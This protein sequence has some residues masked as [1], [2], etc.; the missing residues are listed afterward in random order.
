MLRALFRFL[1][2]N[3]WGNKIGRI[4]RTKAKIKNPI[5]FFSNSVRAR[6]K[7]RLEMLPTALNIILHYLNSFFLST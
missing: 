1:H 5:L 6:V 4:S 7:S 3:V 2:S